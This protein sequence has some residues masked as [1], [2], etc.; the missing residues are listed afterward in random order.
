MQRVS[1]LRPFAV[2][3]RGD[4]GGRRCLTR[5]CECS[6]Q[7]ALLPFVRHVLEGSVRQAGGRVRITAQLIDAVS[8]KHLWSET[9]DRDM[10]DVFAVQDEMLQNLLQVEDL[11]PVVNYR[12]Q[13]NPEAAGHLGV[14]VQLVEHDPGDG[15]SFE[16][17]D[18][19]HPGFV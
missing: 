14:L 7:R 17:D 16:L 4:V 2:Y 15:V 19:P 12:Q 3:E 5:F 6:V 9:Y 8:D 10:E 18:H 1:E 13:N 11:W